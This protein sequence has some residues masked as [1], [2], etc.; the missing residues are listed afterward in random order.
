M[1]MN[2]A[3]C[4]FIPRLTGAAY[5]GLR[6]LGSAAVSKRAAPRR[7]RKRASA[8]SPLGQAFIYKVVELCNVDER[9]LERATHTWVSQGWS[10]DGMQFARTSV[11]S[12]VR[13]GE[14]SRPVAN[15]ACFAWNEPLVSGRRG[16]RRAW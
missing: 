12:G 14:G 7:A 15:G 5:R 10:F 2:A 6:S 3:I 4:E 8:P 11:S 1:R 16:P 13:E 9:A